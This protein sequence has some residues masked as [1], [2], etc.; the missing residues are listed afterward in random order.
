VFFEEGFEDIIG[1]A[2]PALAF[3]GFA[4]TAVFG[5]IYFGEIGEGNGFIHL[6]G[7]LVT[8]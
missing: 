7:L 5:G 6:I 1:V 8:F 2:G 3:V 4:D